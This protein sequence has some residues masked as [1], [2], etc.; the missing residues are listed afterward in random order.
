MKTLADRH[1]QQELSSRLRQLRPDTARRWG[2]MSSHQMVCHL[3]DAFRMYMGLRQVKD[4]S[5][6]LLRTTV[7]WVALWVPTPWPHGFRSA[8]ELDQERDGT[9][10]AE[11]SRDLDEVLAL[12]RRMTTRPRDFGW[13]AHPHF[14]SLSEQEWMRLGY[15]HTSHHLRQFGC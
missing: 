11:F 10:P 2:R 12:M 7:K 9:R 6:A 1:C 4:Q 5:T 14:G 3:A 13:Q 15:L 8:P